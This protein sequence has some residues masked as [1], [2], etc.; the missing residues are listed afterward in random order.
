VRFATDVLGNPELAPARSR[1]VSHLRLGLLIAVVLIAACGDAAGDSTTT[2]TVGTTTPSSSSTTTTT[3]T[4]GIPVLSDLTGAW[5]NERAVLQVNDAGD[6]MVLGPD[7]DPDQPLTL[8]FVARDDVNV[9]FVSGVNGEC[10]G[11]T[12]V[13]NAVVDGE[14]LTL[15]LVE[16]PCTARTEWFE[17]PFTLES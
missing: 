15:T 14:T 7:A 8:G 11:E 5:V 9:I 1:G 4:P 6:Y 2:S 10:P 3:S 16:D 12:G 13:Y 17:L